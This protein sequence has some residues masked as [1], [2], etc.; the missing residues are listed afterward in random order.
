VEHE[1]V[2]LPDRVRNEDYIRQPVPDE[3]YVPE[4]Y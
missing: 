3:M 2:V 4:R 1:Q